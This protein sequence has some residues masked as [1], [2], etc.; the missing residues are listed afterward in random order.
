MLSRQKEI[1]RSCNKQLL[2]ERN[3]PREARTQTE[4]F[5]HLRA[6]PYLTRTRGNVRHGAK[7]RLHPFHADSERDLARPSW[8]GRP[9]SGQAHVLIRKRPTVTYAGKPIWRDL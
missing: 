8:E 5:L 7:L 9:G 3:S 6:R 4:E 1:I 2:Q